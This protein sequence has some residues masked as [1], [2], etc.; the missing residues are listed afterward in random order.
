VLENKIEIVWTRGD[1]ERV[2]GRELTDQEWE[3]LAAE[4]QGDVEE[5]DIP[6][7]IKDKFSILGHLVEQDEP[8]PQYTVMVNIGG[9]LLVQWAPHFDTE[10]AALDWANDPVH[11]W[12]GP[13][14]IV[15]V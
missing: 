12:E 14:R 13:I 1:F 5:I 4:V 8:S 7:R 15:M 10:E 3:V 11:D 6:A 2:I 9:W